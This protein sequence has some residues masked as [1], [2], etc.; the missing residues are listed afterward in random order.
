MAVHSVMEG[1]EVSD[2]I[3]NIMAC[4]AEEEVRQLGERVAEVIRHARANGWHHVGRARWGYRW[5]D[6]TPQERAQGAPM[7]VL[8]LHPDEAPHALEA[9]RRVAAAR[10]WARWRGGPPT[11]RTRPG[12]GASSGG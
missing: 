7:R 9:W 11:C 8:E 4:V 1:G 12:A 6:A 10:A 3:A 5:R 2:F